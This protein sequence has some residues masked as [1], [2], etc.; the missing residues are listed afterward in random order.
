MPWHNGLFSYRIV[1]LVLREL[2]VTVIK[3]RVQS[4]HLDEEFS[5]IPEII[6]MTLKYINGFRDFSIIM[7]EVM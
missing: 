2:R 5:P 7:G 6:A 3:L 4:I 1:W